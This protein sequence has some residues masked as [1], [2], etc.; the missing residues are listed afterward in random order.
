M[1]FLLTVS[2]REA[3]FLDDEADI[4]LTFAPNDASH[5]C[6]LCGEDLLET[7]DGYASDTTGLDC[8]AADGDD[9]AH[10]PERVPL[11]WANSAAI[12]ANDEQDSL[13]LSVSVGDPRGAFCFTVRRIPD[14][15]EGD[16]AGRLVIHMPY[17]GE[18]LPHREITELHPGTFVVG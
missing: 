16:L 10:Q 14:D 17:P 4:A 7:V 12:L 8:P 15:A 5:R 1:F 9:Q 18:T 2:G 11:S 13:T 6:V 3:Q